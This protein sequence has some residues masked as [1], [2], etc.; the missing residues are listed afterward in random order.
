MKVAGV[1]KE[2]KEQ[3]F[4]LAELL[5][6]VVVVVVMVENVDDVYIEHEYVQFGDM[7]SLDNDLQTQVDDSRK[8]I[9]EYMIS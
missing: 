2:Q 9:H 5:G 3:D 7:V 1:E 6:R 4:G 8:Q